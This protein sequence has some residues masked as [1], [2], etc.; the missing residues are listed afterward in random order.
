MYLC[1]SIHVIV[2]ARP[3]ISDCN[4]VRL[5]S[6]LSV[7]TK[8]WQGWL[9]VSFGLTW[10]KNWRKK[11]FKY[12]MMPTKG[13][14]TWASVRIEFQEK[15]KLFLQYLHSKVSWIARSES[16]ELRIL[17]LVIWYPCNIENG[18]RKARGCMP[19]DIRRTNQIGARPIQPIRNLQV[20]WRGITE[21]WLSIPGFWTPRH[22]CWMLGG[23]RA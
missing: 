11:Y 17:L 23:N 14:V 20:A 13:V 9:W 1:K 8:Y 16:E 3:I 4:P 2:Y 5:R 6:Y 18:N 21:H 10:N 19:K 7:H 15:V 12:S 22:F